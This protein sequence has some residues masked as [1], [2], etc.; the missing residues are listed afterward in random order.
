MYLVSQNGGDVFEIVHEVIGKCKKSVCFPAAFLCVNCKTRILHT[1]KDCA[2]TAIHVPHQCKC[3]S[4][5]MFQISINE[6]DNLYV[7]MKPHVSIIYSA[8]LLTHRQ[9][10]DVLDGISFYNIV[11]YS[12][13]RLHEC[14]CKSLIRKGYIFN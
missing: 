4:C 2:F 6:G 11:A 8:F 5:V 10:C 14:L 9:I 13:K 12:N 7:F 1:E 3:N